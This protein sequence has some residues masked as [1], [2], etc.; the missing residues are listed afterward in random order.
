MFVSPELILASQSP[1][2]QQILREAG[3]SFEVQALNADESFE[4]ALAPDEV[5]EYLAR[6][7]SQHFTAAISPKILVTADTLVYLDGHILNKPVDAA[8]AHSM[9]R[10][11]SGQTHTVY[12]GV[13]L[14]TEAQ[15]HSF[16]EET[17][18][19]FHDLSD[20]EISTYIASGSPFDKAGSY[21]IQDWMGYLGVAG[22]NGCFYNVMGFP[23]S[24][25]YRE[26]QAFCAAD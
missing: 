4:E 16:C 19:R 13:C 21:G 2:R 20:A 18:V 14:R 3:F 17:Q 12:T 8:E 15:M 10:Q 24:R 7:K 11:L 9:L 23:V 1:R 5:A 6:H 25:F 26:L 22:I